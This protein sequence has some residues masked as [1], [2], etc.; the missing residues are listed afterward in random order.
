M[1]T[2]PKNL[3][4][5]FNGF[6][7]DKK[8]IAMDRDPLFTQEFRDILENSGVKPVRTTVA[9][10]NLNPMAERWVRS[11]KSEC[12]NKMIIMGE[13]RLRYCIDQYLTH[14]HTS[15][16][17]TGLGHDMID[18][19]PQGKGKIVRQER[20]GGLLKSWRRAA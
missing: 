12:L 20:L 9:S 5:S 3:T 11:I 1:S 4:D 15:R 18:P 8:F 17:H 2:R 6:G 19:Q 7:K 16:P 10:P 13:D 14:Y